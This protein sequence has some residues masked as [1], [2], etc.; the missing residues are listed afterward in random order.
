MPQRQ[1]IRVQRL[2]R[3]RDRSEMI[4]TEDVALLTDEHV[5]AQPRLKSNLVALARD[6]LH[7]DERGVAKS[8]D[9]AVVAHRFLAAR[10]ARARLLLYQRIPIPHEM[11]APRAGGRTRVAVYHR[12][13]DA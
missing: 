12:T 2:T 13:V 11:I 4:R 9:D 3:E 10:I 7:L 6:Q 8:L 5:P 1:P